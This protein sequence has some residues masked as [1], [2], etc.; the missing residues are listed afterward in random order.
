MISDFIQSSGDVGYVFYDRTTALVGIHFSIAVAEE[1][2]GRLGF[3]ACFD[4]PSLSKRDLEAANRSGSGEPRTFPYQCIC[5]A[6][7]DFLRPISTFRVTKLEQIWPHEHQ[8]Q[9]DNCK[10][11]EGLR[12]AAIK[13]GDEV[14]PPDVVVFDSHFMHKERHEPLDGI[15]GNTGK[16]WLTERK[17]SVVCSFLF[18]ESNPRP[19]LSIMRVSMPSP[20]PQMR[21]S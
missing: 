20:P 9:L 5:K 11:E 17:P 15:V 6:V 13:R 2:A 16:L 10:K 4:F 8:V 12:A 14:K 7:H 3:P 19:H 18:T 1:M 21:L